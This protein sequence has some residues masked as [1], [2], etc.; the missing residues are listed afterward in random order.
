VVRDAGNDDAGDAGH[1]VN[2]ARGE[3]KGK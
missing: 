1:W 2:V 3:E